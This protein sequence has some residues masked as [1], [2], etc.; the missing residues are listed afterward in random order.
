MGRYVSSVNLVLMSL[1]E[2]SQHHLRVQML[3]VEQRQQL[4]S[5]LRI[6]IANRAEQLRDLGHEVNNNAA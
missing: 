2:S 3:L 1:T 5:R 6:P 4:G